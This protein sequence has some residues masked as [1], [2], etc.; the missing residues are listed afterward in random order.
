MTQTAQGG[1][2]SGNE[3]RRD[4]NPGA[5]PQ[6]NEPRRDDG[7]DTERADDGDGRDPQGG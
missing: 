4:D 5:D 1:P 2:V 6:A 3:E 7:D